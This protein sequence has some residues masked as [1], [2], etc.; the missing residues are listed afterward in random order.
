MGLL[1]SIGKILGLTGKPKEWVPKA[2]GLAAL[3]ALDTETKEA[4]EDAIKTPVLEAIRDEARAARAAIQRAS[5]GLNP[6]VV[7]ARACEAVS[8]LEDALLKKIDAVQL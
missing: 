7:A 1:S 8:A 5:E 3:S 4:V 2:V 6:Q